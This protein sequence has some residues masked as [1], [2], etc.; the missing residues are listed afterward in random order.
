MPWI[1]AMDFRRWPH[2]R[3]VSAENNF[4][5]LKPPTSLDNSFI[6]SVEPVQYDSLAKKKKQKLE[7][8]LS[9]IDFNLTVNCLQP[10][11]KLLDLS[12]FLAES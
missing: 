10:E 12:L 5:Y 9:T 7:G 3:S 8:Q 2:V 1:R 11:Q 6:R 4:E